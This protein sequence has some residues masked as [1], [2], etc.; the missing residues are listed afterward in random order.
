MKMVNFDRNGQEVVEDRSTAYDAFL[1]DAKEAQANRTRR[2]LAVEGFRLKMAEQKLLRQI[3]SR[4][5]SRP[6][7]WLERVLA[8]AKALVML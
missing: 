2:L 6:Q 3:G 5:T 8:G 1:A 7:G 4:D